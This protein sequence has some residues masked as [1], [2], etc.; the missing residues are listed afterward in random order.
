VRK[1]AVLYYTLRVI[2]IDTFMAFSNIEDNNSYVETTRKVRELKRIADTLD[3]AV[4]IIH[5]KKKVSRNNDDWTEEAIGSQ[6]LTGAAD[7]II[8]LQ[9]KRG[10][11]NAALLIT[12]RDI[13]DQHIDIRWDNCVWVRRQAKA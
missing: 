10:E 2:F 1:S 9:R 5:H 8:S 6:G 3:V 4:V 13:E 12:G 7:C 11:E